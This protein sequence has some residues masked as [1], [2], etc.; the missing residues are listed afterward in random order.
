MCMPFIPGGGCPV[1]VPD[2]TTTTVVHCGWDENS[3]VGFHFFPLCVGIGVVAVLFR[4]G[5]EAA[6]VRQLPFVGQE[7]QAPY[8]VDGAKCVF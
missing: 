7:N 6:P 8:V 5:D 1:I 2:N 3:S 4:L